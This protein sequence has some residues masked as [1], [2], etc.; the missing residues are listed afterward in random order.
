MNS[1]LYYIFSYYF[2]CLQI[3]CVQDVFLFD[4]GAACY[5]LKKEVQ[6]IQVQ[7]QITTQQIKK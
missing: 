5:L 1:N 3:Y 7:I 6:G 4:F 2:F